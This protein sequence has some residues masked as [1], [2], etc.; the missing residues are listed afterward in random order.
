MAQKW[1]CLNY[2]NWHP[3]LHVNLLSNHHVCFATL[4]GS[5]FVCYS[6][7]QL[8]EQL[9]DILITMLYVVYIRLFNAIVERNFDP[10]V[11]HVPF[12]INHIK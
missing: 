6:G 12:N 11:S 1:P 8:A 9:F 7:G 3:M 4:L 5:P 10:L 2:S